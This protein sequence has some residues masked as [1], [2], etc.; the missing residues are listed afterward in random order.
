MAAAIRRA[1]KFD[2]IA[3]GSGF[4]TVIFTLPTW[5]SVADPVAASCVEET[6]VVVKAVVP[7]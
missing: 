6:R 7:R 3:P 1:P 2:G 4:V 5:L